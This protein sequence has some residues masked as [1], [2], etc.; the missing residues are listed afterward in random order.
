[1]DGRVQLPVIHYLRKRFDADHVDTVTEPGPVGVLAAGAEPSLADSILRRVEISIAAH[2]SRSIA[3]VAHA[4]CA[5]NR[6]PDEDQRKQ[7]MTCIRMLRERYAECEV[8]GLWLDD[9][10]TVSEIAQD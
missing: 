2:R 7:L 1:M 4:D 8:I 5:G 6:I 9:S 10:W 3:I